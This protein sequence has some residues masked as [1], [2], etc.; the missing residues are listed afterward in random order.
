[1]LEAEARRHAKYNMIVLCA[2]MYIFPGRKHKVHVLARTYLV[3]S[4]HADGSR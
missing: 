1:M 4:S 2:Q 3:P